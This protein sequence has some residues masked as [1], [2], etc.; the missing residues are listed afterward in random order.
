MISF[1]ER[2]LQPFIHLNDSGVF[3]SFLRIHTSQDDKWKFQKRKKSQRRYNT[4]LPTPH[5]R[6]TWNSKFYVFFLFWWIFLVI[7]FNGTSVRIGHEEF[8]TQGT[9]KSKNHGMSRT[10]RKSSQWWHFWVVMFGNTL[11]GS[12][13]VQSTIL[14]ND[15]CFHIIII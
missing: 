12:R 7:L 3:L 2:A 4:T 8:V 10:Q 1:I 9:D 15:T 11:D 6:L 14:V 5:F 13:S